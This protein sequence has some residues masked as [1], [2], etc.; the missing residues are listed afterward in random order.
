LEHIH[1]REFV[2]HGSVIPAE[3]VLSDWYQTELAKLK[4]HYGIRVTLKH[5]GQ[6]VWDKEGAT[7]RLAPCYEMLLSVEAAK[8]I[9]GADFAMCVHAKLAYY[10]TAERVIEELGRFEDY[11]ISFMGTMRTHSQPKVSQLPI[12]KGIGQKSK[13]AHSTKS[14]SE[15]IS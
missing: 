15:Q 7:H 11:Q 4:K 8:D 14:K 5:Y 9:I 12:P 3:T 6:A 1:D 13:G 2:E 10:R